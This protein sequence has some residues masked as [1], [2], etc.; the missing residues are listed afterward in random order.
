VHQYD[1][2]LFGELLRFIGAF[3]GAP[4]LLMTAT[5]PGPRLEALRLAA[6]ETGTQ[7]RVVDG[8]AGLEDLKRY[9]VADVADEPPWSE[10][11]ATLAR[12]GKVLWVANKVDRAVAFAQAAANRNA[13]IYHSRYRYM[14]RLAKHKAVMDAFN[15]KKPGPAL[16][17]TTQ[18]CEVSLDISAELLVTDM[19]P[20]PALIQRMGRL[21][22]RATEEKRKPGCRAIFLRPNNHRPYDKAD[23]DLA[24][25]WVSQLARRPVS[26][27]DLAEAFAQLDVGEQPQPVASAWLD[28]GPLACQTLAREAESSVQVIRHED[29]PA[30]VT[31]RGKPNIKEITKYATPMLLGPVAGEIGSWQQL[32]PAFIA[33]P[34][35]LEYS[36][37]WGG[38]WARSK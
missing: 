24:E 36:T 9:E 20:I 1:N 22:R 33:P 29:K 37:E 8:P 11:D 15:D 7:L 14:D 2:R 10:V 16:A 27:R 38:K 30:C 25:P 35:R 23:F 34:G 31:D 5:L 3:R 28:G 4:I 19:A 26:Q 17:I 18:V 32:G 13:I 6:R 12:T 21:N